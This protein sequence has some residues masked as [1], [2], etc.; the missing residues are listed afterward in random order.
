MM[1]KTA[2][3][4][5]LAGLLSLLV[6]GCAAQPSAEEARAGLEQLAEET[7]GEMRA[8]QD[9]LAGH[10]LTVEEARTTVDSC[11]ST[12]VPGLGYRAGGRI[13]GAEDFATRFETALSALQDE[14][15]TIESEGTEDDGIH[16]GD[17]QPWA[18]L[19][20]DEFRVSL[21]RDIYDPGQALVVGLHRTDDCIRVPDGTSTEYDDLEKDLSA[22]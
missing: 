15:W 1:R 5:S 8:L 14:R 22:G 12:P 11:Q 10:G 6:G 16:A 3:M 7:D 9:L 17:P 19:A 20:R 2:V 21:K 4:V 13:V 18:N